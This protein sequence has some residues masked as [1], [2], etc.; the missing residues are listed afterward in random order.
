[1]SYIVRAKRTCIGKLMGQFSTLS[2]S[3]MGAQVLSSL[4]DGIDLE[5]DQVIMGQVLTAG[6]GQNPARQSALK[7]GLPHKI[8]ASTVNM[9]CGSGLHAVILADQLLNSNQYNCIIAGGQESMSKAP[10]LINHMR[11]GRKMG[12]VQAVDSMVHDGLTCAFNNYHMGITAENIVGKYALTRLE[13]DEYT[14]NSHKK[15]T[16]FTNKGHYNEECIKINDDDNDQQIRMEVQLEDLAK[17][18][19]AF[20]ADGS[21]TAGN[22]SGINDGAAGVIMVNEKHIGGSIKTLAKIVSHG[23]SGTDPAYMG[24]GPISAIRKCL[25]SAKWDIES[26]DL[27]ECNEAFAAQSLAIIQEL[28]IDPKKINIGGGAIALGHPI[29]A[30]GT[31]ILVTLIHHLKRE[32]LKRGIAALCIGGGQGIAVALENQP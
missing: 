17:L 28:N 5:I 11:K 10:F 6:C 16:H 22:A 18:K 2:A 9:V 12:D 29:G 7:A 27:F 3:D 19:P 13:Q 26:V 8:V 31:R 30:S 1:M 15:A 32:K 25:E 4:M 14:L 23:L 24:L 21:V 20:K